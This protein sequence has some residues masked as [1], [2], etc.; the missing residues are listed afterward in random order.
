MKD[1]I[2]QH[3]INGNFG[4]TANDVAEL[5]EGKLTLVPR[6][7]FWRQIIS[8]QLD[9]DR[10]DY[11]L[12][13][14]RHIGVEYGRYDL[15]RLL[16]SLTVAVEN[17]TPVLV[18][19]EGGLHAAEALIVARYMMFT[20]VYFHSVRSI[21]DFHI[22]EA[23]KVILS[24]VQK[25]DDTITEKTAFPPPTSAAQLTKYLDWSDWRALGYLA[26]GLGGEHGEI[27]RKR[28]HHRVVYRTPEA[29]STDDFD[30][31]A[32]VHA[33]LGSRVAFV[34]IA[35][36]NWYKLTK[37]EE[38]TVVGSDAA[39]TLVPLSQRSSV[40]RN[41]GSSNQRRLY[42]P[43]EKRAESLAIVQQYSDQAAHAAE[44]GAASDN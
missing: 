34:G 29:A 14:S 38:I 33:L 32:E 41:I 35:E 4:I 20:Q 16:V 27:L 40:V 37:G 10:A 3:P 9:A 22:T 17:D 8:S 31:L 21:Y 13:D 26:A 11:L 2:D 25:D 42:V 43:Y 15:E 28:R 18:V 7:R 39:R 1:V 36:K 6:R 24:D 30:R 19:E 23:M 5:I 44:K 12:R